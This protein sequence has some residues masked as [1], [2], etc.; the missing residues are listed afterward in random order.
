[1]PH[2]PAATFAAEAKYARAIADRMTD[3]IL[4]QKWLRIEASYRTLADGS[5]TIGD[6]G[7]ADRDIE[8]R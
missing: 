7:I 8:G 3:P 2:D 1:M 6:L 4:K 5:L